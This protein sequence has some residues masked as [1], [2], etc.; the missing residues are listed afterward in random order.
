MTPP[1]DRPVTPENLPAAPQGLAATPQDSVATAQGLAAERTALAWRRTAI[2]CMANLLLFV[3][4]AA[5]SEYRPVV[6]LAVVAIAALAV[7]TVVCVRR[8]AVLHSHRKG[9]WGNG[10]RSITA[11]A[12][13]ISAVVATALGIAFAY[14]VSAA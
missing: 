3:R 4:A 13:T 10:R 11:F 1:S 2:G 14:A 12:G 8:G 6:I 5:T 9:N 7:V